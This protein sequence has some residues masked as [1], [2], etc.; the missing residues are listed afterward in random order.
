MAVLYITEYEQLGRDS[1]G[2]VMQVGMEPGVASQALT[3][4]T[5]AASNALNQRTHFVR[6][7]ADADFHMKVGTA[8]TATTS[9][10]QYEANVEYY[11]G[12]QPGASMK[13]AA[14]AAA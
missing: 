14:V 13:I 1:Q 10:P 6:L 8:P 3:Y 4:S 2:N 12:V 11:V 5:S 7:K 9:H